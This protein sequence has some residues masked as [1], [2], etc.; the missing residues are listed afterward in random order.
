MLERHKK[1]SIFHHGDY[2]RLLLENV[3]VLIRHVGGKN[4]SKRIGFAACLL[5]SS[6]WLLIYLLKRTH[7]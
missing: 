3:E 1:E 4:V 2:Y 5:E 7:V 6:E